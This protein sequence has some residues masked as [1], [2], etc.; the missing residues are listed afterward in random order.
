M[1][2]AHIMKNVSMFGVLTSVI[3]LAMIAGCSKSEEA[4]PVDKSASPDKTELTAPANE[5][6]ATVP[7]TKLLALKFHHDL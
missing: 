5:R 4:A 1:C 3:A 6:S 2:D 7:G